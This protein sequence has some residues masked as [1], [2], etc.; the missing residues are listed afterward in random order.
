VSFADEDCRKRNLIAT[1]DVVLRQSYRFAN[2]SASF[3]YQRRRA[4][5][6]GA[7][8]LRDFGLAALGAVDAKRGS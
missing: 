8:D 6:P 4:M 5:M 2:S 3:Q 7:G 1:L